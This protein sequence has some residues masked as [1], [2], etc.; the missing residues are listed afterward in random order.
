MLKRITLFATRSLVLNSVPTPSSRTHPVPLMV[1]TLLMSGCAAV[2][3]VQPPAQGHLQQQPA[4]T[5]QKSNIPSPVMATPVLT[6]PKP[7]GKTE[8]YSVSVRNIPAQELLFALARDAKL[9][10]DLHPGIEGAVTINAIDQ[11]LQQI[12]TRIAKQVDMRWEIDGP[13][14]A[15]LPD[16]PFLRNYRVDYVNMSRDAKVTTEVNSQ[17]SSG[18]G[19]AS[20]SSG[21]GASTRIESN[22]KNSFWGTLE[23]NIKDL[24]RETDKVL[25]EGS[26]ETTVE[27]SESQTQVGSVTQKAAGATSSGKAKTT[28]KSDPA[29]DGVTTKDSAA[30]VRKVTFREAASVIT[31]PETGV[32]AVRATSRQHEKIREYVDLITSNARRQVMIEATIVEVGLSTQYEQGINW[33]SLRTLRGGSSG[34]SLA[35]GPISSTQTAVDTLANSSLGTSSAKGLLVNY[36]SQGLGLSSTIQLLETFGTVKVL[37]SP[38]ISVLNNQT[39]VIKVVDN[40]V[41]FTVKADTTTSSAGT[42]QTTVTTTPNTV[43]VGLVMSVTPQVSENDTVLLNVRPTISRLKGEGKRDPNPNIPIP[44]IV[45]EIQTRE[46][47]SMLRLT[48][49]E[50]AV[51][52]GLMSDELNNTTNAVPGLS[53]LPGLGNLFTQRNNVNTKTELVVFLKPTII[54]EPGVTG[55]YS[56]FANQMPANDFFANTSDPTTQPMA[57]DGATRP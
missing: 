23:K 27:S 7:G 4:P 1:V 44:N 47:E 8:T 30:T 34:F 17:V 12:L 46:M 31:N 45:P 22:S 48:N 33:Q 18:S 24:L 9:N 29:I 41:Y 37:S 56:N 54:R 40:I 39:A 53:R 15:I 13:N 2:L 52:G 21:G 49:G 38:K 43:S 55:D 11:T 35:Q 20:G 32:I 19:A 25:P 28:Q 57:P 50:T 51:M 3:P 14:L 10:I 26:S 5:T 6:A 42:G 36:V 16:T